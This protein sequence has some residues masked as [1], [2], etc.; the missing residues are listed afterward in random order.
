MADMAYFAGHKM[1][2]IFVKQ[3]WLQMLQCVC[4]C[5][6]VCVYVRVCVRMC[7]LSRRVNHTPHIGTDKLHTYI[8]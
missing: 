4:V 1:D 8:Q 5:V 6:C 7:A 3:F 2:M